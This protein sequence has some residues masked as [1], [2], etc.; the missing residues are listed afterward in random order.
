MTFGKPQA[1]GRCCCWRPR[2]RCSRRR[3]SCD[4]DRRAG[5]RGGGARP[6]LATAPIAAMLLGT[7]LAT[8]PTSMLMAR[9]TAAGLHSR[10]AGSNRRVCGGARHV[11]SSLPLLGPARSWSASIRASRSF[12]ASRRRKSPTR[13]PAA[14]HFAGAGRAAS[15]RPFSAGARQWGGPCWCRSIRAPPSCWRWCRS[16]PPFL[17]GLNVLPRRRRAPRRD[18]G[19]RSAPLSATG[20][21]GGVVRCRDRRRR[22]DPA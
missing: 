22:D 14:R 21:C 12:T 15:R 7:T 6:E 3:P 16:P 11:D 17:L 20:L 2:R 18:R 19:A 8:V 10:R 13:I 9:G 5:G 1:T 4:D